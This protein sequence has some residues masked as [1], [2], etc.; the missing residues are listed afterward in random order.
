MLE[1]D[2]QLLH[3]VSGVLQPACPLMALPLMDY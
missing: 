3:A 1:A 2:K